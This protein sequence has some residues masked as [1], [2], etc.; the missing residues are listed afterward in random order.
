MGTLLHYGGKDCEIDEYVIPKG[1]D[2]LF[3]IR[4]LMYDQEVKN[5]LITRKI[6][7]PFQNGTQC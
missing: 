2:V 7:L 5:T 3:N 1:T 6:L 4:G